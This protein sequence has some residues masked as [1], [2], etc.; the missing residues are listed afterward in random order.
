M[1]EMDENEAPD[2]ESIIDAVNADDADRLQTLLQEENVLP[3]FIIYHNVPLLLYALNKKS[4]SAADKM[5]E[6]GNDP[7]MF[8]DS[9]LQLKYDGEWELIAENITPLMYAIYEMKPEL[10]RRLLKYGADPKIRSMD[11]FRKSSYDIAREMFLYSEDDETKEILRILKRPVSR[12]GLRRTKR[13]LRPPVREIIGALSV[14][15]TRGKTLPRN[16]VR[17]GVLPF[18]GME[19]RSRSRRRR[20]L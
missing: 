16:I 6:M 20:R 10:V 14:K 8:F 7:N 2:I 18:L 13:A 15:G 1:I 4:Y 12:R 9:I 17:S 11:T 5:I 3:D 19:P